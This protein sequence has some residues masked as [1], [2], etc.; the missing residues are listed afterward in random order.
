M[1]SPSTSD[2][3]A[4]GSRANYDDDIRAPVEERMFLASS[5]ASERA[6]AALRVGT[7]GDHA[8]RD[9]L[10]AMLRDEAPYVVATA[11]GAV[12]SEVRAAALEALTHLYRSVGR[13]PDFGPVV[14][15]RAMPVD[16]V[17]AESARALARL[18]IAK[19]A[20]IEA[21]A[22]AFVD[23]K[24]MPRDDERTAVEAY[25]ALQALGDVYYAV[26]EVDATTWLTPTQAA[27]AA[28]Q[29]A[30]A[31]PLPH[32]R[33]TARDGSGRIIGYVFR[34][35]G[36][37]EVEV[38]FARDL[39]ASEARAF[40]E[41]VLTE[42][43]PAGVPRVLRDAAGAVRRNPDG[44]FVTDGII[45]LASENRVALLDAVAAYVSLIYPSSVVTA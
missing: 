12:V 36:E 41:R 33:V 44:S 37:R 42:V 4:P 20:R 27:V 5:R 9:R 2:K 34:R 22:R 40:V 39:A 25:R 43:D 31:R 19:R 10:V 23:A 14:V 45:A 3:F 11:S 1:P 15:R 28:T 17:L 13:A 7:R 35:D 18:D 6:E 24:V 29:V 16:T 30:S 21:D 8:L 38:D 26:E 32:L